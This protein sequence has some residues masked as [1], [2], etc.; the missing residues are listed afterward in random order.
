[1]KK[2]ICALL[3]LATSLMGATS[4]TAASFIGDNVVIRRVQ[5]GDFVF[6]SVNAKVGAGAEY[7]DNFFSID[8]TD[9]AVNFKAVGGNFS[10]GDLV[11]DVAGLDFDDN[12]ATPNILEGFASSQIF[13]TP[14]KPFDASRVTISNTGL[15]K[16]SF[17]DTTGSGNGSVVVTMG[18]P[19]QA[20][21]PEPTTWAM[22]IGGFALAGAAARRRSKRLPL[23]A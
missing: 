1:M 23:S 13:G 7:S 2:G 5:G 18:A 21:V 15:L 9:N 19:V 17:L 11:Y 8:I 20:P 6:K 16:V 10:L 3:S 14:G 4:A 22:M 12:P